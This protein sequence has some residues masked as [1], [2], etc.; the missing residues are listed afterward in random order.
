[1]DNLDSSALEE[2]LAAVGEHLEA[3]GE[4]A[5]IVVVG[6]GALAVMGWIDRTTDDV[7]V[8]ALARE[9]EG[10]RVLIP[11]EPLPEP[12]LDA[13]ERV[14]RDYGLR[15]DWLN[16][17]VGLQWLTGLPHRFTEDVEWRRFGS[18]NVGFAGRASIIALKLFATVDQGSESV[19]FQDLVGL[20]PTDVELDDAAAWVS[21]QDRTE[22]FARFVEEEVANVRDALGRDRPPR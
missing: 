19:H 6:G 20:E 15:S 18:L 1:M 12:L 5:S 13:V 10:R 2:L 3:A 7:D 21:R 14:A 11:P 4:A 9:Q 17:A 16:T 8:I 22:H